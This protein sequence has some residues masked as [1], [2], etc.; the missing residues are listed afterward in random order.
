M[1]KARTI[2]TTTARDRFCGPGE[3]LIAA[4]A[5]ETSTT[6]GTNKYIFLVAGTC[7]HRGG[8][9]CQELILA[10]IPL[11]V[12]SPANQA[13]A[14]APAK[15][16]APNTTSVAAGSREIRQKRRFNS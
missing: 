12:P 11:T 16:T 9:C 8:F 3:I 15:A 7:S 4:K 2:A 10:K 5:T 14:I 6:V 13:P 1:V